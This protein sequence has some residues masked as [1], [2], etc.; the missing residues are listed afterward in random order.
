MVIYL[1]K[2]K[3]NKQIIVKS[4]VCTV[5]KKIK[6]NKKKLRGPG[7]REEIRRVSA[8]YKIPI[9]LKHIRTTFTKFQDYDDSLPPKK[10]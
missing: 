1:K 6:K 9:G 10:L 7:G 8:V 2:I 4:H 3:I 5:H